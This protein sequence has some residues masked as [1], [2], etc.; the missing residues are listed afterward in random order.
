MGDIGPTGA[1][2]PRGIPGGS[3]IPGADVSSFQSIHS[4]TQTTYLC[5]AIRMS[6]SE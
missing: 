3:G 5:S 2:G 6:Q 4:H 1:T